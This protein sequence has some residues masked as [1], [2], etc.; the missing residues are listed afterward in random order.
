MLIVLTCC[1]DVPARDHA[2][3]TLASAARWEGPEPRVVWFGDGCYFV[4]AEWWGGESYEHRVRCTTDV[5]PAGELVCGVE[6]DA[7]GRWQ[8]GRASW[9]EPGM[10]LAGR[11]PG[12]DGY[13]AFIAELNER[14]CHA[15]WNAAFEVPPVPLDVHDHGETPFSDLGLQIP[16]TI[17][18][19]AGAQ[20]AACV[21]GVQSARMTAH[22]CIDHGRPRIMA[23]SP[24]DIATDL[25]D[26][27]AHA[28]V[29]GSPRAHCAEVDLAI[30]AIACRWNV[31]HRAI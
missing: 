7:P 26:V 25:H 16:R 2:E 28:A 18:L 15:R 8:S 13:D 19:S 12:A 31:P 4:R 1:A 14:R 17:T 20:R 5:L 24:G 3:Q 22:V 23:E 10:L 21:D 11:W 30:P 9:P 27:L 6:P 29:R